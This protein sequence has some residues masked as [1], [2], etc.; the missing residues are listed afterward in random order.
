MHSSFFLKNAKTDAWLTGKE[1]KKRVQKEDCLQA[2][3]FINLWRLTKNQQEQ[4]A[5]VRTSIGLQSHWRPWCSLRVMHFMFCVACLT[6]SCTLNDTSVCG[7]LFNRVVENKTKSLDG[8]L[9]SNNLHFSIELY[10]C[11]FW[12]HLNCKSNGSKIERFF[13]HWRK[14]NSYPAELK[15][16]KMVPYV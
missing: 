4:S 3:E 2:V 10:I 16:F 9:Y 15:L 13:C 14:K 1:K 5:V 8:L 7:F 11:Q 12:W 6:W